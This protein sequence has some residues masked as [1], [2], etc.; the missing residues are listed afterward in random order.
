MGTINYIWLSD[1]K[2]PT[3]V[4]KCIKSWRKNL[5]SYEIVKWSKQSFIDAAN[6]LNIE[7]P[8]ELDF[9]KEAISVEKW[10][11]A[12]DYLR[13]WILYYFGG[14]YLDSDVSIKKAFA[15]FI[16][17]N[18]NENFVTFIEKHN[19]AYEQWAPLID[20]DGIPKTDDKIPGFCLQAAVMF[21]QKG[22]LFSKTCMDYYT[23][24][25]FIYSEN[26]YYDKI[27]APDV[28]AICARKYGFKYI[29]KNQALSDNFG[30]VYASKYVS[31]SLA[32]VNR[33][34]IAHHLCAQSWN[35]DKNFYKKNPF[36]LNNIYRKFKGLDIIFD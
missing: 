12:S 33:L 32:S 36:I 6:S 17:E 14:V 20:M 18:V 30:K 9:V 34:N 11:F 13:Q 2:K 8:L 31:S 3:L 10:A 29:D 5:P 24:K 27:L 1:E 23:D 21:G 28:Y 7:N 22:N 16:D 15:K 35:K 19:N 4:K 25:H 26:E